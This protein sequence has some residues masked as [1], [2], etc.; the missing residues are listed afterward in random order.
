MSR[1]YSALELGFEADPG[2]VPGLTEIKARFP[3][4]RIGGLARVT[5]Y[6]DTTKITIPIR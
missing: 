5:I 3:L 6:S 1:A 2:P 4:H